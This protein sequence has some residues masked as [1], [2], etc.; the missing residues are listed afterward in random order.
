VPP[1]AGYALGYQVVQAYLKR[2][3]KKV[4]ET[5]FVPAAEIIA[6]SQFFA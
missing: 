5:F 6:E 4:V 1:F 3:G 2:S